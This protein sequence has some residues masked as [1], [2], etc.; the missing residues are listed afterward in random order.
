MYI[1]N[2][3]NINMFILKKYIKYTDY[4]EIKLSLF[5]DMVHYL[6]EPK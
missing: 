5:A 4:K 2:F 3:I 6:K 1:K